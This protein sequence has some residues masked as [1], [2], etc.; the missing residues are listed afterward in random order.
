M[1]LTGMNRNQYKLIL[2]KI[3]QEGE[4]TYCEQVFKNAVEGIQPGF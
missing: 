4:G 1:D 2:F 3:Q